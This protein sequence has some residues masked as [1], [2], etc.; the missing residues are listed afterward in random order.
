MYNPWWHAAV[1]RT[2]DA[3]ASLPWRYENEN[4]H[5]EA[6]GAWEQVIR[7]DPESAEAAEARKNG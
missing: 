3:F 6:R 2:G 7:L 4:F 5:S 1:H